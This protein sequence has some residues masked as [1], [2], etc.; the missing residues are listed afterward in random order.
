MVL[1]VYHAAIDDREFEFTLEIPSEAQF[2]QAVQEALVEASSTMM[3]SFQTP[4]E[5]QQQ[6]QDQQSDDTAAAGAGDQ[7]CSLKCHACRVATA[8]TL[9]H[10]PMLFDEVIPPRIEDLPQ[11]ICAKDACRMQTMEEMRG[12]LPAGT[13]QL[14]RACFQCG[15]EEDLLMMASNKTGSTKKGLQQCSRCK[16]AKYCS[17]DCQKK[18]WPLHKPVCFAPQSL[19]TGPMAIQ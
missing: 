16:I 7:E 1:H 19:A 12:I 6:D 17:T 13:L 4:I 8:T 9:L 14:R 10:F 15:L 5:E 18:H 3:E 11:P 2:H